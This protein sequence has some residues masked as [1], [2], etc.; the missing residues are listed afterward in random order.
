MSQTANEGPLEQQTLGLMQIRVVFLCTLAQMFDGFDISSIGMAVPALIKAW[1][2]PGAA[3]GQTFV[4]SSVG[5]ML[6]ALASGPVGDRVGR[7]PV[8]IVSMMFLSVSS[9]L[10]T[11]ASTI[12]ELAWLRLLT[13]IGIGAL[14]PATVALSGDYLPERLRAGIIMVVFTG[15]PLGGF[16]GGVLVSYLLPLYGW[17]I[18]FWLGGLLPLA[19]IP[20]SLIWLPESP[21]ILLAKGR[22]SPPA[23]QVLERLGV[24]VTARPA[25]PKP[26]NP[27]T[28][29]FRD[30]LGSTTILI[31]IMYFSSLLSLYLI[32][33]WMPTVL[34]LTGLTPADAVFAGAVRDFGPLVSI[35][36][37]APLSTK[38]SPPAVLRIT[39]SMGILWIGMVGLVDMPRLLLLFS[40]FMVGC[41]TTG[42]QTGMNGMVG[43]IYPAAIRNTG[44]AWALGVGRLG[45]IFGPWFGGVLLRAGFPPRQIFLVACIAAA[46]ATLAVVLLGQVNKRRAEGLAHLREA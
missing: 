18:I 19:L 36:L 16:V 21:R 37:V 15:S 44:I 11:Q 40:V 41:C 1:G 7:K 24:D 29:L 25:Q 43:A 5:I 9:L 20:I 2:S 27:V 39:L 6:G 32:G 8:L 10:C 46:V 38:Y 26:A 35:F 12:D 42:S 23:R 22:L 31:W 17:Q 4:L 28:G 30:G 34:S 45:A 13:G 14:M 33:Y 3:F